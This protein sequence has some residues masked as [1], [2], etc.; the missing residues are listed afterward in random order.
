MQSLVPLSTLTRNMRLPECCGSSVAWRAGVKREECDGGGGSGGG[1][2][3]GSRDV[4][5]GDR[6]GG[7]GRGGGTVASAMAP[8]ASTREEG[9]TVSSAGWEGHTV[10]ASAV[11]AGAL[12]TKEAVEAAPTTA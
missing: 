5:G 3:G 10:I 9:V 2:G 4:G 1:G 11:A 6:G 8:L 7:E 12:N